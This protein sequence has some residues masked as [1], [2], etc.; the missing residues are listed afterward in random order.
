MLAALFGRRQSL[1]HDDLRLEGE[2]LYLRPRRPEDDAAV[3]AYASDPEIIRYLPWEPA[4]DLE[5]IGPFLK[6]S[7]DRRKH[8]ESLDLAIVLRETD[9]MIGQTD[10]MDLRSLRDSPEL[11][12]ILAR[13]WWGRGLM[14]EAA[15]L[16]VDYGFRA[17]KLRRLTAFADGDNIASQRVMQKIGMRFR[18]R[19]T[20]L[21]KGELRPYVQYGI[22]RDEWLAR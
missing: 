21:V 8:G 5:S 22:T 15:T 7:H 9:E 2:R 12:Y 10:L 11:G 4:P 16:A 6:E 1:F 13:P 3:F 20:R 18:G 17:L 14:T 19:E